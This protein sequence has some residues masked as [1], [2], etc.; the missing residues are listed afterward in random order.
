MEKTIKTSSG[1]LMLLVLFL[2]LVGGVALIIMKYIAVGIIM[3]I[4]A[5]FFV[6][7]GFIAVEPNSSSV[8]TLFGTYIGTIKDSGFFTPILFTPRKKFR[9]AP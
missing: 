1:W 2:M 9:F 8:M 4:S 3:L 7:P 6:A 5:A